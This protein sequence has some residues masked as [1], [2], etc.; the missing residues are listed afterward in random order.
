M[1]LT[2]TKNITINVTADW[3]NREFLP[4]TPDFRLQRAGQD[5]LDKCY[6]CDHAFKDGEMMA[7][8]RFVRSPYRTNRTLCQSCADELLAGQ[9]VTEGAIE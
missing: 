7:I 9:E 3:C 5:P 6:I 8:A 4:M 2:L 1:S